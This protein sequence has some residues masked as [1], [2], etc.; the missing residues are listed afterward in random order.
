M[1]GDQI[2]VDE[3]WQDSQPTFEDLFLDLKKGLTRKR[4]MEIYTKIYNYCSSA[5]EKALTD[6]YQP[7]VKQLVSEKAIQ[8][9]SRSES[10][11]N[12]ALLLFFRN[13]WNEWKMSSSVLKNLLSPVNKIHSSD[14]KT[15]SSSTNS[16]ESVVYSDTLNAWRETAFTPLKNKL[17]VSLLSIIKNDRTGDSANL[18][19]LSDSLECYVQLGPEKNKLEI[20]QSCFENQFLSETETFYKVESQDFIEKN[21]VSEYMRHVYNRISQETNRVNKYMPISTLDKLTKI[22]NS[23]LISNYK[24]QFANKF[25]DILIEDKSAD[26][27]M[28]YSLLNR[29]NYLLP[30]RVTFSDFI[31]SEGLKEIESNLKEAQEKPQVLISILLKVY[32]RFNIMIKECYNNDTDFTTAMDKSFT[33]LVNENPASFDPKKKEST[34]PV[35]LSKFCDQILR[36]GPYHISDETELEQKLTE[37]VCLF[38]YLPDKDIFMLNYQKMLSKRLVEDISASEDAET[39]MINKLK[40][41]QGFDYCTKLTR[42][43]TDMRLCKDI[44]TNFQNHLNEKNLTLPYTFNFYV[45]TNGSWSLT[46]KPSNTPFKPPA[47]MLSSI[48][49]FENFYKKSYQGRVLT[50]LYDFSR[51]DVDSRQ[52]KGK[53]YKLSTTAYQMAILLMF[54]SADKVTRFQINDTIGLD[55]NTVRIPLLSLIKVGVID[56]SDANY[57]SWNNDTEFNVNSKFTSKKMKVNCNISVQIG[58][59]KT[60]EGQQTVSDQ[61]VEKERFFKLQ[62]AIVRIM[63]SKKTLSHNELTVETTTQVSKWFTP[64][65]ASIKKAIEYLID[66]EYIRR[67]NDDNPSARKY[68]YMA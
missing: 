30:L 8:I 1:S 19:V 31:R 67:T 59:N 60:S 26:L 61:E 34:I 53:I 7:K 4:Y 5:N 35:V 62:A 15:T 45:L 68:E 25:L 63:K 52:V 9:M 43:I 23:V 33:N 18:Q 49:Y 10:L 16:S 6:F 22:L 65:I 21:G 12:D 56:C 14:K 3:L 64:K 44:N 51:A 32:S 38:R 37:A 54:N 20:Y 57:K 55:E 24:D 39:L 41:H 36:K 58:E 48:T 40:N 2:T 27:A 28:M 42:M 46:N 50:F 17:S 11:P 66:Q 13:Q 47:E 29:V